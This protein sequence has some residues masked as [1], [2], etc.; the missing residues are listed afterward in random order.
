MHFRKPRRS[1]P[2]C[3]ALWLMRSASA[4]RWRAS[5][6]LFGLFFISFGFV[7][8]PDCARPKFIPGNKNVISGLNFSEVQAAHFMVVFTGE[9]FVSGY[10][11]KQIRFAFASVGEP[12]GKLVPG[13]RNLRVGRKARR[14]LSQF[15][16]SLWRHRAEHFQ[17]SHGGGGP[18]LNPEFFE[19][20]P[21]RA[22]SR[23]T[24]GRRRG[25]VVSPTG[26][27]RAAWNSRAAHASNLHE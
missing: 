20:F 5:V 9:T 17:R 3:L 1:T 11:S 16:A 7:C 27:G 18:N 22:F 4:D 10:C 21:A 23:W 14:L 13:N 25:R 2:S 24:R 8:C 26:F 15:S 12:W 6:T 19:Y